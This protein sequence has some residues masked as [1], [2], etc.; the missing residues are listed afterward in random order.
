MSNVT[1]KLFRGCHVIQIVDKHTK[2]DGTL[3]N[4]IK[5]I[6][7]EC[8]SPWIKCVEGRMPENFLQYENRKIINVLVT[9]DKGIVTKVQRKSWEQSGKISWYWCRIYGEPKAWM[10]LPEPYNK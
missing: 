3:D 10:P 7:E 5:C 9:T 8:S 1:E 4:D 2:D 6:L